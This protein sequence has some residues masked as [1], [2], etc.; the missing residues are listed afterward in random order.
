MPT[1]SEIEKTERFKGKGFTASAE[2][3]F[4]LPKEYYFTPEIY[5]RERTAIWYKSWVFVGLTADLKKVGDYI[6][7]TILD[8]KIYVIRSHDGRLR[9]FY[10]VCQHRAHTLLEG[11]GQLGRG[12]VRCPYHSWAYDSYGNLKSAPYAEEVPGFDYNDFCVPEIRVDTLGHMVFVNLDDD[13]G[14]LESVGGRLLKMFR[15]AVPDYDDLQLVRTASY[16]L[17]CNWKFV[18]DGLECYHCP[19]IHP[20]SMG[21]ASNYL[22]QSFEMTAG[23]YYQQHL[24]RLKKEAVEDPTLIPFQP[25]NT[26]IKDLYVWYLWPH[27]LFASRPGEGNWQI[28]ETVPVGPE[29]S[30]HT[31]YNFSIN[32]PPSESDV[33]QMDYY[34]DLVWPQDREAILRQAQGVRTRGYRRG[35][36]MVDAAHSWWSE[37]GTHHFNNLVW[38]ALNGSKYEMT[39]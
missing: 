11:K 27:L 18:L 8:Q 16:D 35:R 9:G 33:S 21:P 31:L 14:P 13:A 3:S 34:M 12:P 10:N 4:W 22:E 1:L 15:D 5:E 7:A 19:F 25:K 39:P 36:Y 20:Q 29:K 28:L 24:S 23:T 38:Q 32:N 6:T 26:A 30:R 17:D 2:T 37:Q